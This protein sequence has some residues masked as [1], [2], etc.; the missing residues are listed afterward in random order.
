MWL[1]N[2]YNC[3]KVW[4]LFK[5]L[6]DHKEKMIRL[7]HPL[8]SNWNINQ[9]L[10]QYIP[11]D[12]Y[13]EQLASCCGIALL[14]KSHVT[15]TSPSSIFKGAEAGHMDRLLNYCLRR[16]HLYLQATAGFTGDQYVASAESC[17][18]PGEGP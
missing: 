13:E 5:I 6:G 9:I 1:P 10:L 12:V 4:S 8:E 7:S 15:P 17:D 14:V 3:Q 2:S 16:L 11:T 18:A